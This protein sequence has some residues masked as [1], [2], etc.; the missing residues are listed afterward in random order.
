MNESRARKIG[1]A[2]TGHAG[3]L[4][5]LVH[6]RDPQVLSVMLQNPEMTSRIVIQ[7]LRNKR[8]NENQIVMVAS[9]RNWMKDYNLR[10]ELVLCLKTPRHL[11]MKLIQDLMLRDLAV[12]ARRVTLHPTLREVAVNYLKVRLESMRAGEKILLART[13]P[14][15]FLPSLMADK[16]SRIFKAA[17]K[18]YRLTEE[19]LA[20][21]VAPATCSA[22]KLELVFQD[23]RWSSNARILKLIASHK[24]LGYASRRQI[25]QKVQLPLLLELCESPVLDENHRRL[26]EFTIRERLSGM[27]LE[28][29]IMLAGSPSRK[30]L[31]F[32]GLVM[33][34]PDV[35]SAWMKNSRVNP[36]LKNR[37][38]NRNRHPEVLKYREE[39]DADRGSGADPDGS[40]D[41]IDPAE[42]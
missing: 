42:K 14:V 30:L 1:I 29:K 41:R 2:R 20:M 3:D 5:G 36:A 10:L 17:L 8:L 35:V 9:H 16:D 23:S 4:A 15:A 38:M 39:D 27:S 25:L 37:I 13:G 18:N 21:F 32:L 22:E 40:L 26:A 19:D 7:L 34:E 31:F 11:A 12:I 24:N 33:Q 6:E 28:D